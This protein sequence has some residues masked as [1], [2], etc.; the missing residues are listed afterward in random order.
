[1][2]YMFEKGELVFAKLKGHAWWPSQ[3]TGCVIEDK[4]ETR[5]KVCFL[6]DDSYAIV[7]EKNLSKWNERRHK[8]QSKSKH[9]EKALSIGDNKINNKLTASFDS[10]ASSSRSQF[11]SKSRRSA[12]RKSVRKLEVSVEEKIA[13]YLA[14]VADEWHD[15]NEAE[16]G[17]LDKA[18]NFLL[19][20]EVTNVIDL[21]Q[22]DK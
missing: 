17:N 10:K 13:C 21:L 8:I 3:V 5:Y 20:M 16:N 12:P 4:K 2:S 1:M 14:W 6:G 15:R 11:D 7:S 9:L 22:V 19:K 18:L